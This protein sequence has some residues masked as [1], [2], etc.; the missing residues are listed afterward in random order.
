MVSLVE[1]GSGFHLGRV[2]PVLPHWAGIVLS[3]GGADCCVSNGWLGPY[4]H[5]PPIC[6]H[7][8]DMAMGVRWPM[9]C[10]FGWLRALVAFWCFVGLLCFPGCNALNP[11]CGSARPAPAI[12]SL[13]PAT[14][15]FSQVQQSAVLTVNGSNFVSA[16]V[17]LIN[18]TTAVTSVVSSEELQVT[19]TTTL[20]TGPG[21]AEVSVNTPSGNSGGLGC[22]S[23]GTSGSLVLTIT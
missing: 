21:T 1:T 23:G 20:I 4:V 17:V 5:V 18:G 7:C 9:Q 2:C 3:S 6:V 15:E 14:I 19:L 13:S 8:E 22:N 10:A 16:S 11:L 12:S